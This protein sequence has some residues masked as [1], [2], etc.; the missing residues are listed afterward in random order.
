MNKILKRLNLKI[1]IVTFLSVV[2]VFAVACSSQAP[3]KE[4]TEAKQK[5]KIP[6]QPPG[7]NIALITD[8]HFNP[9]YD[10]TLF[11]QL[12]AADA[13]Q[14]QAIFAGSKI[15]GIGSYGDF[16]EETDYNLLISALENM[17]AVSGKPDFV[18][19]SGDFLAHIFHDRYADCNN[20]SSEGLDAF[21]D[22]TVT[23]FA[24][25]FE[26][27]FPGVPVYLSLGNN[28][29][30]NGDY[31][32]APEGDFLKNTAVIFS[33][34]LLKNPANKASFIATYPIGG[35]YAIVPPKSPNSRIIS[36][37]TIFFSPKHKSDFTEYNPAEKQLDWFESQLKSAKAKKE[38]IWLLLHIPPG[39]AVYAT[40]KKKSYIS[41]WV[42][43]YIDR[44]TRLL[45]EYSSIIKASFA[46]H[47]HMDDFRLLLGQGK[48]EQA[49]GFICISPGVS[50]LFGNNPAFKTFTYNPQTFSLMDHEIYYVNLHEMP[51]GWTGPVK[52]EKEY[53][54][55]QTYGQSSINPGTLQTVYFAIRDN[56]VIRAHYMNYYD[57]NH[58]KAVT[59][60][61]WKSYWCGIAQW[62]E[63]E[64]QDCNK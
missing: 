53:G 16:K 3:V 14:W 45:T 8:V 21:I 63:Q 7:S 41:D 34:H 18:I 24:I 52:W 22:K 1:L 10:Q 17:A 27:Y 46:G 26:K 5:T 48:P 29:C 12:K 38:K 54:F 39:A 50:M 35:Y 60:S 25:L 20:K 40:L 51:E 59:E 36:L 64:F 28:D 57:V 37:N 55:S 44:F 56:P 13:S 33:Q 32:I 11:D 47:T 43:T 49:R 58:R 2:L 15:K 31:M 62:T 30:Y 19:F 23:F 9:F 61:N 4:T 6:T 42:P